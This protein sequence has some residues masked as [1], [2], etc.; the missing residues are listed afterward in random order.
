MSKRIDRRRSALAR[1]TRAGF[2]L[3]EVS[4]AVA[5][6]VIALLAMSASTLRTHSLRR[7]NRERA[8]AQ[9]A[10]RMTAESIQAYSDRLLRADAN[11][12]PGE[13]AAAMADDGEVGTE[14]AVPELTRIAN[15]PAVGRIQ[16]VTDE[17]VTDEELG[18]EMGMPRDLNGDG[19][20]SDT[21][22]SDDARMYPIVVTTRW[23]GVSG[24]NVVRHPFY[25]IRY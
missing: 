23:T 15:T 13:M 18:V 2:T 16:I 25:V 12:W 8:V 11:A 6:I 14:F 4:L 17:T 22:V 7:Q 1:R 10:V 9:N 5:V 19:D 3:M 21:D 20:A 24:R